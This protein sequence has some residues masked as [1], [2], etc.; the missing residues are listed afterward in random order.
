M[1]EGAPEKSMAARELPGRTMGRVLEAADAFP[2]VKGLRRLVVGA[3]D[4]GRSASVN[5]AVETAAVWGVLTSASI[6]ASGEAFEE[7]VELTR[8]LPR[9]SIGLHV[10][11]CDG[12][13][14]LPRSRIPDLV[15]DRGFFEKNP[16]RAGIKYWVYRERL[17]DQIGAEVEAQFDRLTAA[18][19]R[20]THVD[21]HHHLHAHPLLFDIVARQAAKRGIAWIRIPR[22]PLS[23]VLR[24]HVPVFEPIPLLYWLTFGL[25]VDRNLRAAHLLGMKAVNNV[26][27]LSG[28][29]KITERYLLALLTH[30]EASTNEIY[31]HPDMGTPSGRNEMTALTSARVR[32]R[33]AARRLTL[34]GFGDLS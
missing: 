26:F 14:V 28:T 6:M 7:A 22:E 16:A 3:D 15:D 20:P 32:D 8:R 23:L 27:G 17:A 11:L 10:T 30:V 12:R 34:A 33:I 21:G 2:A 25:L 4:L 18:G 31:I 5:K 9:L 29:G 24:Q 19:I 1:R 13:S